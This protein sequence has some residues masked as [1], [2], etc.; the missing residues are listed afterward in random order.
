MANRYWVGGTANWDG[1]AGTKW[2]LT[3]GGPGGETVPTSADDVFFDGSSTGTCTISTGN[4]GAKSINCTG[5]TGTI[6][7][8]VDITVS[9]NVTLVAGMTYNF[10]GALIIND[11]ST[12]ISA[13]QTQS[14]I[15]FQASGST[16]TLGD[17][18]TLGGTFTLT[19]GTLDLNG[20]TL[21]AIRFISTNTNTRAITFGSANI[22][23]TSTAGGTTV[24]SMATATGFTFT[25]TGGFTRNMA[26]T[27]TVQF[28]STTGGTTLNA[29]NLTINAGSSAL[30][31]TS[32]SYFKNINF[33]GSTCFAGGSFS[34]AGNITLASGGTYTSFSPTFIA[35]STFTSNG[36]TVSVVTVNGSGTTVT[37]ADACTTNSTFTLTAGTI[38]LNGN[39]LSVPIFFSSGSTS[40][41]VTFGSANIALTSVSFGA[42]IL[43]IST[44]GGF[45][46]STSG[47]GF[48]RNMVTASTV[49]CT[50]I[51]SVNL[52]VNAGSGALTITTGNLFRNVNF[53]GS[54]STASGTFNVGGNLTLASGG[55]YTLLIPTF[56]ATGTLTSNGRTLGGLTINGF[57][58]TATLA[59]ALNI[60]SAILTVT[61]GTFNTASFNV[62]AGALS[63]SNT[64]SR[65]ITLGSSTVTLSGTGSPP[66][67]INFATTTNLTFNANT[68]QIN[69]TGTG[70][71]ST[72]PFTLSGGGRTFYNVSFTTTTGTFFSI[73][74]AN[75][76]NNL[77][78][79]T[80]ASNI[81]DVALSANQ[82]V[83]G[84]LTLGAT[85][86]AITR[87]FVRSNTPGTARTITCN[88]TLATLNDVDFN[89]IT[90]AG[91]VARPWT[92]TRLGNAGNN[93][94]I[95]F[96]AGK[97]V[98]WNLAGTQ[99]W[100][101]TGW[102][103]T[104]NGTPAVNNF[105]LAQDTAVFTEAGAAGT[106]TINAAWN[107]GTI[108]MADGV[109]NR[110]TAFTLATGS[111]TPSIYGNVTLF[112]NLTISGTGTLTFAGI[113]TQTVT[114]AGITFTPP[115]T[116]NKPSSTF[117]L[118]DALTLGTTI[119]FTLTRGTL[120]LNGNTLSTG[121]FSSD[122]NNTRSITF[123][124]AN[125]ALTST[126]AATTV[127]NIGNASNFTFT[128]TGAFTRNMA[129]T[130]TVS[131]AGSLIGG[132]TS[133][134][135][136]LTVN[137]G[138]SALTIV[139]G[140]WFKNVDFTGSTSTVT[141]TYNAA[142][143]LTLASGGTYTSVATEF[144][145]SGT[146]TSTGKTL[147]NT[148]INGSG[149]TVTLGDAATLAT[150]GT[151]GLTQGT[152]NL[153]GNTLST[154]VFSSEN[155][156][157]RAITFGSA[158]IALT[159]TTPATIVLNMGTATNFTMTTSGGGF[160]RNMAATATVRFG[161]FAGGTTSNAP[162]L[163]VNAGSSTLTFDVSTFACYFKNVDFT[164]YSG[165]V[166]A[167]NLN[168]AGNLTLST[169]GTYTSVV[170]TF[171]A[172]GTITSV[173][174]TLS[175]TTVNGSGIT[176][177]LGDAA[178]LPNSIFTLTQGTLDLNGNTLSTGQFIS[179][180][181]NTRAI[182][183]GSANIALALN[184]AAFTVLNIT[185]ATGFTWTGTGGFT[186]NMVSTA[187]VV[188]GTTGG[189]TS[190]APNLTVNAGSSALTI[191][192]NSYF[193]NLNFTGYT[194]TPSATYNAAGNLTLSTGGTYTSLVPTFRASG[195]LTSTGKTLGNTT[196][197]GSG[198][199]VTLGDAANCPT[200]TLTAGIL[201]LAGFTY[202][203]STSAATAAGTKNLTFNGGTLVCS[204]ATT[205]AWNNAQ[206]TNFT[207]TAGTGTGIISMTAATAKT[208]VGGGSTYNCTLRQGGAGALTISGSNT[209]NDITNSTQPATVTFTA[210]TTQT[211][212]NFS[213]T[214]TAGNLI[215]INSSSAG[216]QATLSK[217]SGTVSVDYLSIRDSNAT[218]GAAWYAGANSTNVSNNTGWIFTA[219][220]SAG[221]GNFLIFLN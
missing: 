50:A 99:N 84:T 5:F 129:A 188:F 179:T 23:L 95:T 93:T 134:A 40:R 10:T 208:F 16:L 117:Q 75:T 205:T 32:F 130:A 30:T 194:G 105:P 114:S 42:T 156:N 102:A 18:C 173:G 160:T 86:T 59:D 48:T 69:L 162:N 176:V 45:S 217:S 161:I 128:G 85:N 165:T 219:P 204:A 138:S 143:N 78:F 131:F 36:K 107:I 60:G 135:P 187:T 221:N 174:K 212:T 58:I 177:T 193:K 54:T 22:A 206:P 44:S 126:V 71:S 35:T 164:G 51:S 190:N 67:A 118:N 1:T 197:N 46:T 214:G 220:P 80:P 4:T 24:L 125:I 21:S 20:N 157:T 195:T 56:E 142:G 139:S 79:T 182:T 100:D 168:M 81:T 121:I 112:T 96:D 120:D 34:A 140:S 207:T 132:T 144:R 82:T 180:N 31:I 3:S 137:A 172:S 210:G 192:T 211:F 29:P 88:G 152:L 196:V 74:G 111:N 110:T 89:Y 76:F 141:A 17:A 166:T 101:A 115:I 124:S 189:T 184:A 158:N 202:T 159:T 41:G 198:I 53:T 57:G 63:S 186:R 108:Q 61:S 209:F 133:N 94:D 151:F 154:G 83:N 52:T 109:S 191:T 122:N 26:A 77:T 65:T 178:T 183:F 38:N 55:T 185:T 90:A 148:A 2:A 103:T 150:T 8:T 215:T 73:S 199:T 149:I 123:G 145:A 70:T 104:N 116:V 218:G 106:V 175:S 171:L 181:T 98:Y 14:A 170:P 27:A 213:L 19:Q 43:D 201:D 216:S 155:S 127:L 200:L 11:A 25:G 7:G 136:N 64:N 62:T 169:G 97:T 153:N 28:G 167:N 72:L 15:I 113:G 39:T 119:T 87:I 33:T 6:A 163:T 9:G 49:N 147:G 203:A 13:G 92:G 66:T 146:I 37:L 68:S 47:G 91:T 12:L